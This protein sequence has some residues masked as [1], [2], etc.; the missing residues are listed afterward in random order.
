MQQ[1]SSNH[2]AGLSDFL[3]AVRKVCL[4]RGG[5]QEEDSELRREL[6]SEFLGFVTPTQARSV[7]YQDWGVGEAGK[8]VDNLLFTE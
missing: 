3:I 7:F 6:W 8:G 4:G 5:E 2:L 1:H